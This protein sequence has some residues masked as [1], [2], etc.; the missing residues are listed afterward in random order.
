MNMLSYI[1]N[2]EQISD[3]CIAASGN[4][5]TPSHATSASYT[6]TEVL[7]TSRFLQY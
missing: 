3:R 6:S 1:Q 4:L 5:F 2:D 7:L